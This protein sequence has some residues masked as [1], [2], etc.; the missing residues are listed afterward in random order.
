MRSFGR[1]RRG[2]YV[3]YTHTGQESK[4]KAN[5]ERMVQ[6]SGLD[7]RVYRVEVPMEE[8][9]RMVQGR[10]KTIRR[11]VYPGYVLVEM[12]LDDETWTSLR[13]TAG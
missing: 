4:V 10:K 11:K 12:V 7:D 1:G 5:I 6:A 8:E 2:W 9:T 13:N 3:I